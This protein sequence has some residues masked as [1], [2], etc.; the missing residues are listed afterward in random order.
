VVD[1]TLET[2]ARILG[3]PFGEEH[4]VAVERGLDPNDAGRPA[5]VGAGAPG[6]PTPVRVVVVDDQAPFR[7]A[8][9][10]VVDRTAGFEIVGEAGD[11]GEALRFVASHPVD[12]VLM[13]VKMPVVDGIEAARRIGAD[14]P[15]V[16]VFLMSSHDRS[17]L[18]DGLDSCGAA[19][20]L[21]KED[22]SPA[23]LT[24][25]WADHHRLDR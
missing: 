8:A 17:S 19:T 10:A 11:G 4:D 23:V 15:D 14:H 21:P 7:A 3:G 12:L 20:Y 18:P 16:V 24:D 25:L 2:P 22:L 9:R 1:H 5:D 6:D 13:D